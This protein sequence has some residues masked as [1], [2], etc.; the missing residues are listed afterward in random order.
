MRP[1]RRGQQETVTGSETATLQP[2]LPLPETGPRLMTG[3]VAYLPLTRF[4]TTACVMIRLGPSMIP[5]VS[6]SV[7]C[8]SSPT[9]VGGDLQEV[10]VAAGLNSRPRETLGWE[11]PAE[12]LARLP[13][14]AG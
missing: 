5:T 9:A 1:R 8:E 6:G 4:A 3:L 2:L 11:T 14:E 10:A 7:D 13:A 12:R